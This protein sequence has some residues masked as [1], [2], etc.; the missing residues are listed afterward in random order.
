MK[1]IEVLVLTDV[2]PAI[3]NYSPAHLPV[4][5]AIAVECGI[6]ETLN[7]LLEWDKQQCKLSPGERLLALMTNVLTEGQPM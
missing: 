7:E 5:K 1:L 3:Y 2:T 6:V 4:V